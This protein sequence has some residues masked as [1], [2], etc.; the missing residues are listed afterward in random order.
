[1][2]RYGR[3]IGIKINGYTDVIIENG[4][5]ADGVIQVVDN[6]L[7][8]PKK[9]GGDEVMWMGE[10]LSVEE[11]KERLEPFIDDSDSNESELEKW[12]EL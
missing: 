5:A 7:I 3:L 6:V 1:M 12:V 10:K 4:I 8:P 9:V 2:A 11:L